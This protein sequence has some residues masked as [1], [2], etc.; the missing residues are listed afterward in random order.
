LVQSD[1][2][3]SLGLQGPRLT[4]RFFSQSAS[5]AEPV[6]NWLK[7][8][9]PEDRRAI[10]EDIKAAQ[11]GWPLGLP[12]VDHIEGDL[13]E[14]RSKLQNRIAR[15]LFVVVDAQMVLLHGFIKK[16]QKTPGVELQLARERFKRLKGN[17]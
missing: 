7:A 6:R 9:P 16:E 2:V 13:W 11:Y 12:L 3:K 4:V 5:G 10:G 1:L 8:L 14:I 15:V 17:T